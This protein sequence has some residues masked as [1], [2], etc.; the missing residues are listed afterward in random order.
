MATPSP[1][2]GCF[3]FILDIL[4]GRHS[5]VV[6]MHVH[7]LAYGIFTR[8]VLI[9]I[10]PLYLFTIFFFWHLSHVQIGMLSLMI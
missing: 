10:C 8:I 7:W 2:S 4:W 3:S 6:D 9:R 1:A 5:G